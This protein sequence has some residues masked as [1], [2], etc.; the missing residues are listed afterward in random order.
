MLPTSP[1]AAS[2]HGDGAPL[3]LVHGDFNTGAQAWRRQIADP[4]SR[5]LLVIDRRGY[6]SSLP[7]DPPFTFTTDAAAALAAADAAGW[8]RF[9]LAG[10]SYGGLV[11]IETVLRAPDRIRSLMLIEP[12]YMALLPDDPGVAR[13]R[14]GVAAIWRNAAALSDEEIA[15]GFFGIIA[16]PEETARM[17]GGRAWPALVSQA[18]R[19]VLAESPADYPPEALLRLPARLPVAVL[20]GG[21]SNSGLQAIARELHCRIPGATLH[22][23]PEAGHAVQFDRLVFDEALASLS[24]RADELGEWE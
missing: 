2:L 13:M 20:T 10:H 19:A 4:A 14:D 22:I 21:R 11:A 18:R 12:P 23:S 5:L 3:L 16:G 9:D 1:I 6:G 15:T 24:M 7:A 17:Q 8:D